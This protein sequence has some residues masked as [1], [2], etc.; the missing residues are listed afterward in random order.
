MNVVHVEDDRPLKDIL[1]TAMKAADPQMNLQQF[2][3]ADEAVIYVQQHLDSIDLV[4]MDIRLPGQLNGLQAAELLRKIGYAADLILTSAYSRPSFDVLNA[5]NSEF[6][7]KP[8]HVVDVTSKMLK[9]KQKNFHKRM[10]HPDKPTPTALTR[11]PPMINAPDK[12]GPAPTDFKQTDIMITYRA[13][14]TSSSSTNGPHS[15]SVPG[16]DSE[17]KDEERKAGKPPSP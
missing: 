9:L 10:G 5:L 4:I 13:D 11:L 14:Q 17:T 16:D 8:W 7:P 2:I 15:A 6:Y 1:K 12:P 3:S